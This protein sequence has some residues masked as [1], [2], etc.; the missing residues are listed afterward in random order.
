MVRGVGLITECMGQSACFMASS[1]CIM[2]HNGM[3]TIT[4]GMPVWNLPF[5]TGTIDVGL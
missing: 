3:Q 1:V 5:E 2:H 4:I